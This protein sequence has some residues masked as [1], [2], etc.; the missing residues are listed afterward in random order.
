MDAKNGCFCY[1]YTVLSHCYKIWQETFILK[2]NHNLR[3]DKWQV[4]PCHFQCVLLSKSKRASNLW[5][6]FK[7]LAFI[8][9]FGN[10]SIPDSKVY[11]SEYV[12]SIGRFFRNFLHTTILNSSSIQVSNGSSFRKASPLY[13]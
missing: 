5:A 6:I 2:Q 3:A 9:G 4:E 10:C 7:H 13:E 12:I 8:Y 1:A 11:S